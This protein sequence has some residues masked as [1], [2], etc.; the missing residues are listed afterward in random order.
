MELLSFLA[1]LVIPIFITKSTFETMSGTKQL[2][3]ALHANAGR[4]KSTF[5]RPL[6]S[7]GQDIYGFRRAPY[8]DG[9][10]NANDALK[11]YQ[12]HHSVA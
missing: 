1:Q 3:R 11:N 2:D 8:H 7:D 4:L 12:Q 6:I 9:E 10:V 5:Q